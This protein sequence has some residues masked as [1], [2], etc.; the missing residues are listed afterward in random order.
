MRID[1]TLLLKKRFE[2]I[3]IKNIFLDILDIAQANELDKLFI[4]IHRNGQFDI[5]FDIEHSE[6]KEKNNYFTDKAIELIN[7]FNKNYIHQN[8]FKDTMVNH[9]YQIDKKFDIDFVIDLNDIEKSAQA[10]CGDDIYCLVEQELLSSKLS[11]CSQKKG[12]KI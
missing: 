6:R 12:M 11:S 2:Q 9:F 10:F 5:V 4:E 3:F 1:E 8:D 7:Q